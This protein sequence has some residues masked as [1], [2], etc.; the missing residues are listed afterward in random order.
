MATRYE[1]EAILNMTLMERHTDIHKN[2]TFSHTYWQASE[3]VAQSSQT[4]T[5]STTLAVKR[6][7]QNSENTIKEEETYMMADPTKN[8]DVFLKTNSKLS[9][10]S[11][12]QSHQEDP[13]LISSNKFQHN[14]HFT[15]ASLNKPKRIKHLDKAY[16]CEHCHKKFDRPW[17]LNGHMRLH[18]GEKPFVCPVESCKKSFADRLA[19]QFNVFIVVK[20]F[21]LFDRSNLRAH[22]RTKGHHNWKYQCPQCTKAFS[23]ESYLNR[24]CLQACRKFLASHKNA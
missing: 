19:E 11:S 24:H 4:M 20:A 3:K 1:L 10:S 14:L 2:G 6:N 8:G 13:S 15:D 7:A 9:S 17:V 21:Y 5:R 18:T 22:Q 12:Y 16:E 23:Q